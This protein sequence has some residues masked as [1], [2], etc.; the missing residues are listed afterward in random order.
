MHADS[1]L[2]RRDQDDAS[3]KS[4]SSSSDSESSGGEGE[5]ERE[6]VECMASLGGE[7]AGGNIVSGES[8]IKNW[9][10]EDQFKQVRI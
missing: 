9:T 2:N 3:S 8:S 7:Q 5:G 10:Y 4:N 1:P 6:T